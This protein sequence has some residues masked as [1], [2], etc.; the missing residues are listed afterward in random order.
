[1][2]LSSSVAARTLQ[3]LS[4][5]KRCADSHHGVQLLLLLQHRQQQQQE[6][7][8]QKNICNPACNMPPHNPCNNSPAINL[9]LLMLLVPRGLGMLSLHSAYVHVEFAP[10]V[11]SRSSMHWGCCC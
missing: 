3:W 1:L 6:F 9:Y 4:D 10:S 11:A 5:T 8:M 2:Q 7:E